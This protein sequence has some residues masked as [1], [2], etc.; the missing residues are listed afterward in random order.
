[1]TSGQYYIQ[2]GFIFGPGM[3]GGEYYIQANYIY[4]PNGKLPWLE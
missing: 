4:G 1:M 2:D 3:S